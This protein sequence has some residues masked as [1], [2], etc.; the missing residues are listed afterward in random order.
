LPRASFDDV[1]FRPTAFSDP[2]T[3]RRSLAAGTVVREP[4]ALGVLHREFYTEAGGEGELRD[5]MLNDVLAVGVA[6]A[7]VVVMAT[8]LGMVELL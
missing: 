2:R 8:I 7:A 6:S 5:A 3:A 4:V 1:R